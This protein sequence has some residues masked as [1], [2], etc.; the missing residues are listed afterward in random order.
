[1]FI[2]TVPLLD[3]R[4]SGARCICATAHIRLRWSRNQFW[5]VAINIWS[6]RDPSNVRATHYYP[7]TLNFGPANQSTHNPDRLFLRPLKAQRVAIGVVE[8]ELFGAPR[9][10]VWFFGVDAV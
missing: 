6:L 10:D 5:H 8:V 9:G 7:T 4:S 2:V 3:L 1:M